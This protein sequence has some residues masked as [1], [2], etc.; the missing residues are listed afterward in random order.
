MS[1]IQPLLALALGAGTNELGLHRFLAGFGR[2]DLCLGLIDAS[3]GF[4][5]PRVLQLALATVVYN[6][7]T[8][9]LNCC[10]GLV[11]LRPEIVVLQFD[12]EVALVYSLIVGYMNRA[13]DAGHLGAQRC[14]VAA[15]VSVISYLF[16]L[17]ALPRIPVASDSD[18]N[19]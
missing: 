3:K 15:D 6:G 10:S 4:G 18:Q 9:S 1:L 2:S 13:H 7:S 11:N 16:D 8:G 5:D 17:A 14:Q 12:N 19:G